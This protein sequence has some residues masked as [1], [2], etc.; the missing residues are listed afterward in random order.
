MMFGFLL[1][2]AAHAYLFGR[3]GDAPKAN[4][5]DSTGKILRDTI[6]PMLREHLRESMK[7][8]AVR[9]IMEP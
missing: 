9:R 5:I 2:T 6:E 1:A 8:P 7:N 3:T 4:M